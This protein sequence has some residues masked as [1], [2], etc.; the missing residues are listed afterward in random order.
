MQKEEKKRAGR[1]RRLRRS[2]RGFYKDQ[3]ETRIYYSLSYLI[4]LLSSFSPSPLPLYQSLSPFNLS[5]FVSGPI[6]SRFIKIKQFFHLRERCKGREVVVGSSWII[7]SSQQ[8]SIHLENISI[9]E[10]SLLFV[11]SFKRE[12]ASTNYRYVRPSSL[13]AYRFLEPFLVE[14][15]FIFPPFSIDM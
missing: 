1:R 5:L 4:P 11:R 15:V 3:D 8:E 14:S 9:K 10:P 6:S 2:R 13:S 7:V 12:V